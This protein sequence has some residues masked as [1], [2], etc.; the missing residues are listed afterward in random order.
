MKI[1]N[2]HY[3]TK[4]NIN[5]YYLAQH[6]EWQCVGDN[7]ILYN[8]LFDSVVIAKP[9]NIKEGIAFVATL[10]KGCSDII[11]LISQAFEQSPEAV[12]SLFINKKIIE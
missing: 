6:V 2:V 4:D 9:K 12:Y 5:K 1:I 8:T 7:L 11:S 10:E 3:H